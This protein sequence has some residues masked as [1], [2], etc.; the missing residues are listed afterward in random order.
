MSGVAVGDWECP[1]AGSCALFARFAPRIAALPARAPLT[2]D[3]LLVP[4]FLLQREGRLAIYYAPFDFVNERAKVALVGITPGFRQMEIAHRAARRA[5]LAGGRSAA[6]ICARVKY[7]ASFA[8][9]IRR[10]LVAMLDGIGLPAALG[11]DSCWALYGDRRD[12]LHTSAV[13]RYPV[14]VD[15]ADWTGH[16]PPV[17]RSPVLQEYARDLLPGELRLAADALVVP[18]GKC[19]SDA[20][21]AL[22]AGGALDPARCL[23]GLPHPSGANGHRQA[24]Y[25]RMRP[26]LSARVAVWF[27]TSQKVQS[28]KHESPMTPGWDAAVSPAQRTE[29]Q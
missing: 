13:V 29:E 25:E 12:L 24:Q 15:G 23:I 18:L 6:D 9:P 1:A 11:I 4:D 27:G 3:D 2:R 22:A 8:G 16:T 17:R 14:F 21:G 5:V 7:E 26:E 28:T 10:N 19:A 20:V